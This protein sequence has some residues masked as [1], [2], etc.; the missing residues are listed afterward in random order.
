MAIPPS[1]LIAYIGST[2]VETF[3]SLKKAGLLKRKSVNLEEEFIQVLKKKENDYRSL[4]IKDSSLEAV[5]A[6]GARPFLNRTGILLADSDIYTASILERT[7]ISLRKSICRLRA[8]G[9]FYCD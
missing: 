4:N 6:D 1:F 7:I 2:P 5:F 8:L 9:S 3:L